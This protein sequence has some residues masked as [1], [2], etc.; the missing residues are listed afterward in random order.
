MHL[1]CKQFTKSQPPAI[2]PSTLRTIGWSFGSSRHIL[3]SVLVN[4]I[5]SISV[6]SY[7]FIEVSS[8][9]SYYIS[10][11]PRFLYAVMDH[12]FITNTKNI[13]QITNIL[14]WTRNESRLYLEKQRTSILEFEKFR[15]NVT[16]A[17]NRWSAPIWNLFL[18]IIGALPTAT[19]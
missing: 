11:T 8:L 2:N 17:S 7:T 16:T 9:H 12:K 5:L 14:V 18:F 15:R 6:H 19:K 1:D 13:S 10:S 3:T 4:Y